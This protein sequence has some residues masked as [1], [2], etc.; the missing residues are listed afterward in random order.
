MHVHVYTVGM[1]GKK[2]EKQDRDYTTQKKTKLIQD[3]YHL[4]LFQTLNG[5]MEQT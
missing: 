2:A 4:H 5:E 1:E 3:E